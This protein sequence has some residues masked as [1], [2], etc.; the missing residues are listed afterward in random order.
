V[1]RKSTLNPGD[2]NSD[3]YGMTVL[4]LIEELLR[5]HHRIVLVPSDTVAFIRFTTC[6]IILTSRITQLEERE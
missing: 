1:I 3:L 2:P 4:E 5:S 6:K